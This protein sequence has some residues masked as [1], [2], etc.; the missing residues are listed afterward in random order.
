MV[1]PKT[2]ILVVDDD[3]RIRLLEKQILEHEGYLV[4]EAASGEDAV[5]QIVEK[6]PS[7]V[8]LDV[9][10]PNL[11][12]FATCRQIREFS[13]VPVIVVTGRGNDEDKLKGFET[14]ADDYVTKPFSPKELAARV[15]AVL[16]RSN[17]GEAASKVEADFQS[18]DLLIEFSKNRV[19]IGG[20]DILLTGTEHRL[21]AY[22]AR[23]AGRILTPDQILEQVWGRE[24]LGEAHLLRVTIGRLRDKLGDDAHNP[25]YISTRPGIGYGIIQR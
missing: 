13:A 21:L 4:V 1:G 7:L 9:I 5:K 6:S 25:R 17:L 23:S 10:M 24:Y 19:T 14:G 8:L 2:T 22:L 15:K 16:R 18:G 11:D 20:K 3:P 12:G